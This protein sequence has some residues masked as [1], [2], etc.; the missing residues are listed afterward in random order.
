[1]SLHGGSDTKQE[2]RRKPSLRCFFIVHLLYSF[3]KL[4][5]Y[6]FP[7]AAAIYQALRDTKEDLEQAVSPIP[8]LIKP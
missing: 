8:I 6:F 3:L 5:N 2:K 7:M 4:D 1:M